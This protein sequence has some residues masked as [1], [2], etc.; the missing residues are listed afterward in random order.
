MLSSRVPLS[1]CLGLLSAFQRLQSI[2]HR[3]AAVV[4]VG[5]AGYRVVRTLSVCCRA[6]NTMFLLGEVQSELH[7]ELISWLARPLYSCRADGYT[8]MLCLKQTP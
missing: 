6:I 1:A 3:I 2:Q 8:R 4:A 7:T 5:V